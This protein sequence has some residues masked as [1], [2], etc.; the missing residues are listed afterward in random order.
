[1]KSD[2]E[3]LGLVKNIKKKVEEEINRKEIETILYWKGEIERILAKRPESLA[4]FRAEI[5]NFTQRM[6]N[7]IK[8]LKT[9]N[10]N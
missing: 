4:T 1:M 10:P 3:D 5:Q 9:Y 8:V 2:F 6:Q 7:R